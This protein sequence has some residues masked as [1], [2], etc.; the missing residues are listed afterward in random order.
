MKHDPPRPRLALISDEEAFLQTAT[1]A[2]AGMGFDVTALASP[3]ALLEL[4]EDV[5]VDVAVVD[6]DVR[7][8]DAG[9]FVSILSCEHPAMAIIAL[10]ARGAPAPA[11]TAGLEV[12]VKPCDVRRVGRAARAAVRRAS[13]PSPR[14]ARSSVGPVRL[15]LVHDGEE[16]LSR[17]ERVMSRRG[18]VVQIAAGGVQAEDA[19]RGGQFDVAVIDGQGPGIGEM[20]ILR[21]AGAPSPHAAVVILARTDPSCIVPW[22]DGYSVHGMLARPTDVEDLVWAVREAAASARGRQGEGADPGP[23]AGPAN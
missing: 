21:R 8:M 13:A 19:L 7:G 14:R 12:F 22:Q 2:L 18:M 23:S 4:L 11:G 1:G 10:L 20:E 9:R 5:D 17:L 16:M 6:C 3:W 15:L